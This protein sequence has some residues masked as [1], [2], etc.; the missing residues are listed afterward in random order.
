MPSFLRLALRPEY[1]RPAPAPVPVSL[2]PVF[3]V[4]IAVWLVA[5][6]VAAILWMTGAT[7]PHGTV[8]CAV[9]ALL[10]TAGL[11]WTHQRPGR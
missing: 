1:R 3:R 6:V 2:R 8:T 10:G 11:W 4:G 7:G 9:G 5:L